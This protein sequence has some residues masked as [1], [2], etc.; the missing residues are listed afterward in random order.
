MSAAL[1]SSNFQGEAHDWMIRGVDGVKSKELWIVVIGNSNRSKGLRVPILIS[2][3][4][5][6]HNGCIRPYHPYGALR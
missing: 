6:E 1:V 4:T 5:L 2:S 3:S